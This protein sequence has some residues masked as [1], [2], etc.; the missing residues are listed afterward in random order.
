MPE[1]GSRYQ[2]R[3]VTPRMGHDV[4]RGAPKQAV[5]NVSASDDESI[6]PVVMP[7]SLDITTQKRSRKVAI[8][9]PAL[10]RQNKSVVLKRHMVAK[11]EHYQKQAKR[12]LKQQFKAF[13]L[14]TAIAASVVAVGSGFVLLGRQNA[15]QSQQPATLGLTTKSTSGPDESPVT[16]SAIAAYKTDNDKPRVIR[17]QRI[18]LQARL[19]P[20]T[21]SVGGEPSP[22]DNIH[23]VGWLTTSAKPGS[24]GVMMLNGFVAGPTQQ[25]A[26]NGLSGLMTGDV[27]QVEQGDG[28]TITYS[29]VKVKLYPSDKVDMN[30]LLEPIAPDKPGLSLI[31]NTG[32]FNVRTNQFEDRAAVWAIQN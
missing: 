10:P 5:P 15:P 29:V 23:D 19:M 7:A 21:A 2:P 4:Q 6:Q 27:I 25:G 12:E 24:Q 3:R 16:V 31:A 22:T 32:R 8:S 14:G 28:K 18:G 9:L 30:E 13:A 1:L 26:F 11:A 17:I 20:V